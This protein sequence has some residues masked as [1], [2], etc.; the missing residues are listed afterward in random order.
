MINFIRS[1]D[2]K[3]YRICKYLSLLTAL[4][5]IANFLLFVFVSGQIGTIRQQ[6]AQIIQKAQW[7]QMY[8]KNRVNHALA[9]L[10]KAIG[11]KDIE[12]RQAAI[13]ANLKGFGIQIDSVVS[14]A[15]KLDKTTRLSSVKTI[16]TL[17]GGWP[18][19]CKGLEMLENSDILLA[20]SN[21]TITNEKEL[22]VNLTYEIFLTAA[23]K[24][25]G[26]A[27]NS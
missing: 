23:G 24:E 18:N 17:G 15:P 3:F 22:S 20:V 2:A 27:Q 4:A 7:L 19:I 8:E 25:T 6:Q 21:V 5:A 10:P 9:S 1:Q 12:S 11:Q 13:L 16:L 14:G 26:N